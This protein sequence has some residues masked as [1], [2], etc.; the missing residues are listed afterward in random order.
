MN[1]LNKLLN[2]QPKNIEEIALWFD[3]LVKIASDN[4]NKHFS[5][6]RLIKGS[7]VN[8]PLPTNTR[9]LSSFR[10]R[11][12]TMLEYALSTEMDKMIREFNG[13]DF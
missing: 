1:K 12:G 8:E 2:K 3:E 13:D 9:Q 10:T 4:V 6:R 7:R 11:I 5:P